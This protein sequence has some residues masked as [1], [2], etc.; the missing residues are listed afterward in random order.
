MGI[1][2]HSELPS[3]INNGAEAQ[4]MM[5]FGIRQRQTYLGPSRT[6]RLSEGTAHSGANYLTQISTP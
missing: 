1:R 4:A 5:V 2:S 3:E 6:I